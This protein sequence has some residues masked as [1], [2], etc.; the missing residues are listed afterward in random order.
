V[1]TL[2]DNFERSYSQETFDLLTSWVKVIRN[3]IDWSRIMSNNS[4][5]YR[6]DLIRSF[7]VILLTDKHTDKHNTG[8]NI[9]SLAE[10]IK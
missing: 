5:K 3:L 9:T 1:A 10:I 2:Y 4:V 7:G 6:E 8:E